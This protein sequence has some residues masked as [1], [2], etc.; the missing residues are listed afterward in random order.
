MRV[1]QISQFTL[2]PNACSEDEPESG[3]SAGRDEIEMV[4]GD[5]LGQSSVDG[6]ILPLDNQE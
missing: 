3:Q 4:Q 6:V 2:H 1:P 5:L